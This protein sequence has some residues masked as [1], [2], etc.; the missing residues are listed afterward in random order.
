MELLKLVALDGD[1][2]AIVS[3]HVQ[4]AVLKVADIEFWKKKG[5]FVLPMYR[6]A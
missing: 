1:D 3:A 5:V 6:F 4:D 2:L